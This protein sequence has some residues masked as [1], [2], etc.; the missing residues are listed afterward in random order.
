MA[1]FGVFYLIQW[2]ISIC[3]Y[4]YR[5]D[6]FEPGFYGID[7]TLTITFFI[8]KSRDQNCTEDINRHKDIASSNI[9]DVFE[10]P[11][12]IQW[13]IPISLILIVRPGQFWTYFLR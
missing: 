2:L 8:L 4:K 13:P 10:G 7:L 11:Y 9:Y 5:Q 12:L 3:A 6:S 1:L